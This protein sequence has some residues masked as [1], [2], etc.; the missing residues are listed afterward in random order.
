VGV[1]SY[2]KKDTGIAGVLFY[3]NQISLEAPPTCFGFTLLRSRIY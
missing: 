3:L 2:I 1:T